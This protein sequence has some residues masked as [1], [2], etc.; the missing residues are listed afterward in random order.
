M[1]KMQCN[2]D[3][4]PAKDEIQR[5]IDGHKALNKAKNIYDDKFHTIEK[6]HSELL[7]LHT[8]LSGTVAIIGSKIDIQQKNSESRHLDLK[9]EMHSI[10]D[11]VEKHILSTNEKLEKIVETLS[12]NSLESDKIKWKVYG[13][14]SLIAFVALMYVDKIKKF[15]G[16]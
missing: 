4:C 13:M 14:W 9:E 3:N 11:I 10:K 16:L 15:L 7:N 2:Y 8:Q 6:H 5:L 1:E 12:K